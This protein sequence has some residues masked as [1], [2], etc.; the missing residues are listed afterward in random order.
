VLLG[1]YTIWVCSGWLMLLG[2][3]LLLGLLVTGHAAQLHGCD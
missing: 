3:F 1:H 2:L